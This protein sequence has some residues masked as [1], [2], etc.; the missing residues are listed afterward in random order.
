MPVTRRKFLKFLAFVIPAG[1]IAPAAL[2][3]AASDQTD[4]QWVVY[5][6]PTDLNMSPI[7]GDSA[8]CGGE[9]QLAYVQ[10]RRYEDVTLLEKGLK[11]GEM[12]HFEQMTIHRH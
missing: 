11:R 10:L 8:L 1:A 12:G 3:K 2:A 4:F 9:E 7:S 6:V 5:E